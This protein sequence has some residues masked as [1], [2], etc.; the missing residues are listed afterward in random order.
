LRPSAA[1]SGS[2]RVR[3]VLATALALS[4]ALLCA[5]RAAAQSDSFSKRDAARNQ[6]FRAEESRS[7][8]QSRP[9][10]QRSLDD[11]QRVVNSYRRVYHI[12][13]R[14]AEVPAALVAVAQ[15]YREMGDRFEP[16]FFQSAIDAYQ[17]LLHDYPANRYREDVLLTVGKIEKDDLDQRELALKT[18]EEF[19]RLHPKSPRAQ[20][21][22][23][24]LNEMKSPAA[25]V[26]KAAVGPA[27]PPEQ[28][29]PQQP[30]Q[31]AS[32]GA[33]AGKVSHVTQIRTWDDSDHTRVVI[34]LDEAVK[35]D[36]AR[37]RNPDRIYFDLQHA[38]LDPELAGRTIGS[39]GGFLKS[40]RVAQN[41]A[42]IVRIVLD[43]EKAG[44][45]S[46]SLMENPNRLVVDVYGNSASART[47][48]P[49]PIPV[50]DDRNPGPKPQQSAGPT[51]VAANSSRM[52]PKQDNKVSAPA[53][54]PLTPKA[55]TVAIEDPPPPPS[56]AGKSSSKSTRTSSRSGSQP[57]GPAPV[58]QP[59]KDGDRS[60][61]RALGLKI[62]RIVIDA[63]HGGHDTGTIGPT[64][65]MEKDLCLDV[66]LRLGKMIE[67]KLPGAEVI[68]TR[69]DDTFI[70]LEERTAIANRAHADLFIS[71]HANS[72]PD[73]KARGIETYYLNFATSPDA[74]DVAAR[75]NA[76]SQSSI[77][78]LQ[79]MVKKIARNEK[80]EESRELAGDVQDSLLKRLQLQHQG[81]S[82]KDRGVRKAPFVVLI[83]ADMPSILS[84]ISFISNP[85]DEQSLKKPDG[86][87]RVAEG[88][89]RGVESYLKN[90]NSIT[91]NQPKSAPVASR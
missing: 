47:S 86:R 89:Y 59:T 61:T 52:P 84:E 20:E 9:A 83:G 29:A 28:L 19:L 36:S 6:F 46:A 2:S 71:I 4:V 43:V 54:L 42:G 82:L 45:Y 16:K 63:G 90:L 38:K 76:L 11:Y 26:P 8:L 72:S 23:E 65:L 70:P 37:I 58:P 7:A 5:P 56:S 66:T 49:A 91:Y 1:Q 81:H 50:N 14:A 73:H 22:R 67:Q 21:A 27:P 31:A 75:E 51:E 53:D 35:F 41:Q 60:L 3:L 64:G 39:D 25:P 17:F 74:L 55:G 40:V 32:G 13:P 85:S 88:L 77:H 57:A 87:Q 48:A 69:D 10:D 15:L 34:E 78:D 33:D 12:T 68:Y 79:D 24:A 18:Y 80:I 44:R 30:D 62:G